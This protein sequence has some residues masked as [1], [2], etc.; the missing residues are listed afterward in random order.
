[1]YLLALKLLIKLME[2]TKVRLRLKDPVSL[3]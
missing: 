1:M 3:P 2:W